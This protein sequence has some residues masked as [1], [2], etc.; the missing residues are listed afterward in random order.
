MCPR[1]NFWMTHSYM[2]IAIFFTYN[3]KYVDQMKMEVILGFNDFNIN[4]FKNRFI[5]FKFKSIILWICLTFVKSGF[6]SFNNT[7]HTFFPTLGTMKP[8]YDVTFLI[9]PCMNGFVFCEHCTYHVKTRLK[10]NKCISSKAGSWFNFVT[11][12]QFYI[13]A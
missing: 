6:S 2:Q 10:V 9:W 5:R 11:M 4:I 1:T 13:I 3:W 7:T 8:I 12:V